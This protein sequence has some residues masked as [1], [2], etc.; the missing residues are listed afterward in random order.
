MRRVDSKKRLYQGNFEDL[1]NQTF[2]RTIK[3]YLDLEKRYD[4]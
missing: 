3:E 1:V 4:D 2:D